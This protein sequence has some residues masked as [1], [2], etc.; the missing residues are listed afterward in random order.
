MVKSPA[1][2]DGVLV[3]RRRRAGGVERTSSRLVCSEIVRIP[4]FFVVIS[5]TPLAHWHIGISCFLPRGMII[6]LLQLLK[7]VCLRLLS[8][9][10]IGHAGASLSAQGLC[11][12]RRGLPPSDSSPWALAARMGPGHGLPPLKAWTASKAAVTALKTLPWPCRDA[13][14]G[15]TEVFIEIHRC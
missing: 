11:P 7:I 8:G 5:A 13:V 1:P 6:Q 9:A 2:L 14:R 12:T 3:S 10:L 4:I 15:C